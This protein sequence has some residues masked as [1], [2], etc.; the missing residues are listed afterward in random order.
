ME[1]TQHPLAQGTEKTLS[2][3]VQAALVAVVAA[4]AGASTLDWSLA[5]QL[6]ATLLPTALT[7]LVSFTGKL[8]IPASIPKWQQGVLRVVRTTAVMYV[9][10]LV[11]FLTT[12]GFTFDKASLWAAGAGAA[13]AM[14]AG[15]KAAIFGHVG[16]TATVA[17]L[18]ASKDSTGDSAVQPITL[19]S[20][21][22]LIPPAD[23]PNAYDDAGPKVAGD[24]PPWA[25]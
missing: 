22:I 4:W 13:G 24:L 25:A 16:N 2:T 20:G 1:Q 8:S 11:P 18:P 17:A 5:Q 12:P 7:A 23:D 6:A 19:P 3:A 14:L 21:G 10:Y 15:A 9:G